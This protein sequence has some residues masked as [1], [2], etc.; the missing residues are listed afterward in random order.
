MS[1]IENPKYFCAKTVAFPSLTENI[2]AEI[3]ILIFL[4]LKQ[5]IL[6]S[7]TFLLTTKFGIIAL[8]E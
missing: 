8:F 3:L 2:T 1:K 4:A 6:I 5:W 7:G